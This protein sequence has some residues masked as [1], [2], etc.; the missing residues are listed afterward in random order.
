MTEY[1]EGISDLIARLKALKQEAWIHTDMEVWLS[2]PQKADF[3]YFPWDYMQSL[4]DNEVYV[5]DDG[6]ELPLALKDK[7]LKEW[8]L[9]SVLTHIS[10]SVNWEIEGLQG[11]IDQVNY[12]LEFDTFKR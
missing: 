5:D 3:H 11:F 1:F 12:Y 7:S 9:V 6:M 10:N 8:M 4:D 2:N